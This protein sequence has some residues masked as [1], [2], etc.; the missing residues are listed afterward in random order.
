MRWL[1]N[2]LFGSK[3][4]R[5]VFRMRRDVQRLTDLRDSEHGSALADEAESERL[6]NRALDRFDEAAALGAIAHSV[7]IALDTNT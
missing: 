3:S 6:K 5:I 7:T 1:L 4:D 2:L